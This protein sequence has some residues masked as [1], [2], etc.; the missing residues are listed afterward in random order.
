[1]TRLDSNS[2]KKHHFIHANWRPPPSGQI[3]VNTDGALREY[4]GESGYG[5]DGNWLKGFSKRLGPCNTFLA[6]LWGIY[7]GAE[8]A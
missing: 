5:E 3:M 6:E 2:V 7:L 4:P 8:M 1:M